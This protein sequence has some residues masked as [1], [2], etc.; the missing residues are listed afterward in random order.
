MIGQKE[1]IKDDQNKKSQGS[2]LETSEKTSSTQ[3]T[4]MTDQAEGEIGELKASKNSESSHEPPSDGTNVDQTQFFLMQ[5][6]VVALIQSS[7]QYCKNRYVSY[8][9]SY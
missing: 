3:Q 7:E 1:L 8:Q 6:R 9:H 2:Q 5:Y 4:S